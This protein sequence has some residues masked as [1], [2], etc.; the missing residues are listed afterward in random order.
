[1]NCLEFFCEKNVLKF[2][3]SKNAKFCMECFL[4]PWLILI[5]TVNSRKCEQFSK[6]KNKIKSDRKL[7][8]IFHRNSDDAK[9]QRK[10]T[11]VLRQDFLKMFILPDFARFSSLFLGFVVPSSARFVGSELFFSSEKSI[12][13]R[14]IEEFFGKKS[15]RIL[16]RC[17]FFRFRNLQQKSFLV[18]PF[19]ILGLK[20]FNKQSPEKKLCQAFWKECQFFFLKSHLVLSGALEKD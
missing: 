18:P 20:R 9:S 3:H 2:F 11:K 17:F 5:F 19:R 1:M 15:L 16:F 13:K 10:A 12:K 8:F 7:F 4:F 6:L 14:K